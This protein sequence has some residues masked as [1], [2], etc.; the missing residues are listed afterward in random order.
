MAEPTN[1]GAA[2]APN[3]RFLLS[4]AGLLMVIALGDL[5]RGQ[6]G[7]EFSAQKEVPPA[8]KFASKF[9]GPTVKFLYCYS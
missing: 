5:F 8:P 7:S 9:V 6:Y 1:V 3:G 4:V 2:G